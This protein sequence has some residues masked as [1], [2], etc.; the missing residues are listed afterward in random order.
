MI[1]TGATPPLPAAARSGRGALADA[2]ALSRPFWLDRDERRSWAM[3]VAVV[4]LT[5]L[6]VWL[7]VRFSLWNNRFFDAVQKHDLAAF[8]KQ[9]G[10]F[11]TLATVYIVAAVYRQYLQ[12]LL[13]IRWRTHLTEGLLRWWLQPGAA[14]RVATRGSGAPDN[15]DQ[16][17]ADDAGG[18]ATL[19]L[20]LSL[21]L[22]NAC[23]TLAS[24]VG[25]LWGLSGTLD[26]GRGLH[27]Q[28]YMVWVAIVY[29]V[30]GS[31]VNHRLGRR[32]TKISGQQ[33]QVEADFRYALVQARDHA[34]SI[35]LARG[36]SRERVRL[37]LGFDAIR[38]N[39]TALIRMNKRLTW[40]SA[41]YGQIAIVFPL[42][43]A[44]PRYFAGAIQLGGLMQTAQAFGQVQDALSWFI[45]AY[46]SLANWRATVLRLTGFVG[47]MAADATG[48]ASNSISCVTQPGDALAISALS[49]SASDGTVLVSVPAR[50][51]E[52]GEHLLISG[53]SGSGKSSI[54][55][56]IA[57]IWRD[58]S[59]SVE[60][61]A[62]S[63]LMFVPQRPYLPD[64]TLR[65]ALA[66][67]LDANRFSEAAFD[68]VLLLA[69]L[70]RHA[71]RLDQR[72]RWTALLSPGEQQR[73]HFARVM[74]QRPDWVFLDESTSALDEPAERDL[75]ACLRT[76]C[77]ATTIVSIGHRST[78]APLH[79]SHW[80]VAAA[81]MRNDARADNVRRDAVPH[82]TT[83]VHGA[84]AFAD[85]AMYGR[86]IAQR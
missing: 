54:V 3:L 82:A 48:P 60:L 21:G 14:Y 39:W 19:T 66:Y 17:I 84:A 85:E 36:E 55:R 20:E 32:L 9:I 43:V 38:A 57:G 62:T 79:A 69:G 46:P 1:A 83:H 28:G 8:W 16:R 59:G 31:W 24:F 40:F 78:L 41:G 68:R 23:V 13:I 33:Q 77:P 50:R 18:F 15:P 45:S 73:V 70:Q 42:L 30:V 58:G 22:L 47:A 29:A 65:D 53:P 72:R 76:E 11:C 34:E 56:A 12:Q 49:V 51:F 74:L 6:V 35:A 10:V 7:N 5:L 52:R 25:I 75:Y 27:V 4:T 63:N 37:G 81:S 71:G 80:I 44:A 61:P 2:W 26:L 86:P 64:G 67:P